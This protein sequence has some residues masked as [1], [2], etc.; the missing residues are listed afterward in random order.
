MKIGCETKLKIDC[1]FDQQIL[2]FVSYLKKYYIEFFIDLDIYSHTSKQGSYNIC[3][4]LLHLT[5][6]HAS[7]RSRD[8][9]PPIILPRFNAKT[10]KNPAISLNSSPTCSG[11]IINNATF[12]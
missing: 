1:K 8:E 6:S 10:F 5:S 11:P 3:N 7:T 12:E 4:K 9:K 2:K